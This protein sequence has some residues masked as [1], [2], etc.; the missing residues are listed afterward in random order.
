M[1]SGAIGYES[2]WGFVKRPDLSS[3]GFHPVARREMSVGPFASA[4]DLSTA[5]EARAAVLLMAPGL[6]AQ[7]QPQWK[8]IAWEQPLAC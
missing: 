2:S 8:P 4:T 7:P 1:A 6:F 5:I 3:V